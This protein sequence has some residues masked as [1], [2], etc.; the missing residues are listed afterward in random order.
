MKKMW[1]VENV[2][3]LFWL[4]T[5]K[6]R[7]FEVTLFEDYRNDL[8]SRHVH[9]IWH[10]P[11]WALC[12]GANLWCLFYLAGPNTLVTG[13]IWWLNKYKKIYQWNDCFKLYVHMDTHTHTIFYIS[14]PLHITLETHLI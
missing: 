1:F 14:F 12:I 13:N 7:N 4:E 9:H 8:T 10:P 6:Q 3:S 11:V 2:N 5:Q